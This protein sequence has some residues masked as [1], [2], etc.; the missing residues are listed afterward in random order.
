MKLAANCF[1]TL[2]YDARGAFFEKVKIDGEYFTLRDIKTCSD[3]RT[4]LIGTLHFQVQHLS[5]LLYSTS[6]PELFFIISL[7]G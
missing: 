6:V 2:F 1:P 3:L 7:F 4:K 5:F